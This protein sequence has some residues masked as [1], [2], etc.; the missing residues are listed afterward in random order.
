MR[1][2][3][4]LAGLPL[5]CDAR[6]ETVNIGGESPATD[7]AI[8]VLQYFGCTT[9]AIKSEDDAAKTDHRCSG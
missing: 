7:H 1:N 4:P 5:Y 6:L 8:P 2:N 3:D 9:L